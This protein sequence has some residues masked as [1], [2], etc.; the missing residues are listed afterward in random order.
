[1]NHFM[2]I[3]AMEPRPLLH[4]ININGDLW[5]DDDI[6]LWGGGSA[7]PAWQKLP[8]VRPAII[9]IMRAL[10]G[11]VLWSAVLTR[12]AAGAM[13]DV[14]LPEAVRRYEAVI[15]AL[16]GYKLTI[17]DPSGEEEHFE[18]PMGAVFM[19]SAGAGAKLQRYN[20]GHDEQISLVLDI[21]CG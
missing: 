8:Q 10:D 3:G 7:Q 1:M 16:P 20:M 11:F 4:A 15:Y 19:W 13:S 21:E 14:T 12:L 2:S 17:F 5:Q 18:P 9:D 6:S